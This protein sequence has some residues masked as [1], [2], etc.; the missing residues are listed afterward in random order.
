MAVLIFVLIIS[1]FFTLPVSDIFWQILPLPKLVQFPWR[2][3]ALTTFALAVLVGRL[4][5]RI[6]IIVAVL[7]I[8]LALP[9]LKI[10]RT[11]YPESYYT[12]NDDTTTV[13]NEYMPKGVKVLPTQRSETPKTV[14][15]PGIKV[16]VNGQEV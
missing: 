16:I 8:L 2:F 9:F 6:A 13:Q 3:L 12:T 1:V 14:Y 15:F 4:P 10:D 5:K 11:F 7:T